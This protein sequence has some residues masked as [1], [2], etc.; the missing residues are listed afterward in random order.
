MHMQYDISNNKL[1]INLWDI[2]RMEKGTTQLMVIIHEL[3]R[4]GWFTPERVIA[5]AIARGVYTGKT[6]IRD[7]LDDLVEA[8]FLKKRIK[9]GL[10]GGMVVEYT[11]KK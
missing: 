1:R 3:S 8:G 2:P 5:E 9:R 7:F 6:D 4:S 11:I 10:H